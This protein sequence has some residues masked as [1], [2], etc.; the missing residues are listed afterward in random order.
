LIA[1]APACD[2]K[3]LMCPYHCWT[4]DLKGKLLATPHVGGHHVHKHE[5]I[6]KTRLGLQPVALAR[7]A[8]LVFV[9]LS[10]TAQPFEQALAPL[11]ARWAPFDLGLLRHGGV[12]HF[13]LNANWKLAIENFSESYHLPNVHPSLTS[14]S[15]L[16]DHFDMHLT[17]TCFGQGSYNY[18]PAPI[19]GV[20]LPI[21]PGIPA[22]LLK[23]AEYPVV[24]PNAM[25]GLHAD[26]FFALI[27]HPTSPTTS[28]EEM[29]VFFVGDAAMEER[30]AP[31]RQAVIDRWCGI[32]R[33]DMGIVESM[34]AGR[35]SPAMRGGV[36][37]P[38]LD[39]CLYDFQRAVASAV[40]SA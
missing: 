7:W 14:Y 18:A 19:D 31:H 20:N 24:F 33:E 36:F 28:K 38:A 9:N 21:F 4:Y 26:H 29:H 8:G 13:E 17:D 2:V 12:A 1:T 32:N 11:L 16:E 39:L 35:Y 40:S 37:S 34:Q 22:E 6:D 15:P 5:D 27:A 23:R 30:F 3:R 25:L 10:G